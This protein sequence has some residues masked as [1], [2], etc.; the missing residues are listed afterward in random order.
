MRILVVANP[1]AG[2]GR[3]GSE[4]DRL[5]PLLEE[6]GHRVD[7]AFTGGPGDARRSVAERVRA[8]PPDRIVVVGGDGTL[9]EVVN[10]LPDPAALP[11]AQ[12]AVGTAN[13]LAREL[14]LPRRAE[15][16][17]DVLERGELRRIDVG[18][19]NGRRFL[20]NVSCGFDAMVVES[21]AS[22]RSG[23]LGFHAYVRPILEGLGRY[24]EP[25][26]AVRLDA[27]EARPAALVIVSNLQNYGGLF[28]VSDRASCDS[29][30]FVVC[31]CRRARRRELV[32][33]L[34]AAFMR[35][36]SRVRG[37][38]IATAK[39][40]VIESHEPVAIQIDGDYA[41]TTPLEIDLEPARVAIAVPRNASVPSHG[42][43]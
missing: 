32:G 29:G 36:L 43:G 25:R 22:R 24:R 1:V 6:R 21:I 23:I 18:R 19:A 13:M 4:A 11:V 37:V 7:L 10:G 28:S 31:V 2:A 27:G 38:E 17:V 34:L 42:A 30:H 39:R 3:G 15:G 14:G 40:I 16:V 33:Y 20:M 12:L 35:R 41:G 26:L 9:N 8:E 5:V